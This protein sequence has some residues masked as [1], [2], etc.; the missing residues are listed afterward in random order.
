MVEIDETTVRN[1][2]E[3]LNFSLTKPPFTPSGVEHYIR[4]LADSSL[5]R[6]GEIK[7]DIRQKIEIAKSLYQKMLAAKK[8]APKPT[9]PEP[10]RTCATYG[11]KNASLATISLLFDTL[12]K[13][14]WLSADSDQ[15]DFLDIFSGDPSDSSVT[16][17]R[18]KGALRELLQDLVDNGM[19][20]VPRGYG[21]LALASSHFKDK[22]GRWM[23]DLNKGKAGDKDKDY[24]IQMLKNLHL[25][26]IA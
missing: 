20:S 2:I 14:K 24:I 6:F 8:Q 19:V 10:E 13:K 18:S 3:L 16:W 25:R 9:P 5:S 26:Q 12:K 15:K 7:P 17:L 23:T 22:C 1:E 4:K 11:L 21:I